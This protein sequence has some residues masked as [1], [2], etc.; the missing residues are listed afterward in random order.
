MRQPG[1]PALA[2][3]QTP[4]VSSQAA[5]RAGASSTA[6][7]YGR[8]AGRARMRAYGAFGAGPLFATLMPCQLP[9]TAS[10][11]HGDSQSAARPFG[12]EASFTPVGTP[13]G[14]FP[15]WLRGCGRFRR[16]GGDGVGAV[17]AIAVGEGDLET[18]RSARLQSVSRKRL[19]IVSGER[20]TPE[21]GDARL[22]ARKEARDHHLGL[23]D[24]SP[25]D[26]R[27]ARPRCDVDES[28]ETRRR[29]CQRA[30]SW[31]LRRE[32]SGMGRSSE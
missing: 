18:S 16:S 13:A 22:L 4:P 31:C 28:A 12:D 24:G 10:S 7:R 19:P 29:S 8:P 1:G 3:R 6:Q 27:H 14:R 21:L 2:I 17:V 30:A 20:L 9:R 25:R 32:G 5:S 11:S 15:I 23:L 26:T